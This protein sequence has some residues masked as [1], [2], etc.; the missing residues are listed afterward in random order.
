MNEYRAAF[1]Y[2]G[3]NKDLVDEV[4]DF[5]FSDQILRVAPSLSD[6]PGPPPLVLTNMVE[7]L[8]TAGGWGDLADFPVSPKWEWG[9]R[10][11]GE[12]AIPREHCAPGD[13]PLDWQDLLG[14][15]TAHYVWTTAWYDWKKRHAEQMRVI[16]ALAVKWNADTRMHLDEHLEAILPEGTP[17]PDGSRGYYRF[18][19]VKWVTSNLSMCAENRAYNGLTENFWEQ[20]FSV[21]RA[22]YWPCGWSGRWPQPGR[23][24]VWQRTSP[25]DQAPA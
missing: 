5:A 22:G 19:V 20:L 24:I 1:D 11:G 9:P 2:Q 8:D 21:Y 7:A 13:E 18:G 10:G 4:L 3:P 14:N 12:A 6:V 15:L 16:K 25:A 23:F 17:G